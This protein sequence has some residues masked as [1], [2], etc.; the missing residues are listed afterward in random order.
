MDSLLSRRAYRKELAS[1][2]EA[3]LLSIPLYVLLSLS[4]CSNTHPLPCPPDI[5]AEVRYAVHHEYAQTAV[6]VLARRTRLSFLNVN[7]ALEALPRVVDIMADELG[8]SRAE[9][10]AQ[11]A[12]AV[13]FFGSMGLAPGAVTKMPAP[14]PRGWMEKAW[15]VVAGGVWSGF[16]RPGK[17]VPGKGAGYSYS[18]ARFEAGELAALEAAFERNGIVGGGDGEKN[19]KGGKVVEVLREVPGYSAISE[20]ECLYVLEEVGFSANTDIGFHEFVE[21]GLGST[22]PS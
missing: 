8:W 1:S 7:A 22:P 15:S 14:L 4:P 20:K 2:R 3:S 11:I 19:V 18:R 16:G 10:K 21:V 13:E 17:E 6:D 12:Q 9:R 5:E